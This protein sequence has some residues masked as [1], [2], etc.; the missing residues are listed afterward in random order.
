MKIYYSHFF[1]GVNQHYQNSLST[2]PDLRITIKLKNF[3]FFTVRISSL[4]S[5]FLLL[6][7]LFNKRKVVIGLIQISMVYLLYRFTMEEKS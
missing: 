1:N 7:D 3:L 2:D 5:M 6:I 4:K